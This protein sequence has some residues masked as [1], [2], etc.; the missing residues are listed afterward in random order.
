MAAPQSGLSIMPFVGFEGPA[1]TGKTF[2][3]IEA[4]RRRVANGPPARRVLGLTFMHGSRRR[5]DE[6]FAFFEETRSRSSCMT[7]DSFAWNLLWRWRSLGGVLPAANDFD[8]VC[9]ACGGLLERAEVAR[10]V[11]A[12]FPIIAID[13]AQELA[14]CRLR[15]AKALAHHS[16]MIVAA[17]EFQCLDDAIDTAP[18]QEWFGAG[19]ITRLDEVRRTD[20]RGLLDAGT[21]LRQGAAPGEGAG[22]A[23]RYEYPN[24]A[25]FAVGHVLNA[26]QG[27]TAVLVAPGSSG[28]AGEM[29]PRLA[30]GMRTPKQVV[31]PIPIRWESKPLDEAA[32]VVAEVCGGATVTSEE[33]KQR[34]SGLA[35]LAPWI[36]LAVLS[37]DYA[38]RAQ[39]RERWSREA[40]QEMLE[41]KATVHRAYGYGLSRGVPVMSIHAAK[42]RQFRNVV[43]L[44][45]PGVPG[46]QTHHARLLYNAITRAE[47]QCTVFVRTR[48]VLRAPPFAA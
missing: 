39:G 29:I 24:Q 11:T 42:N 46:D 44:W 43:V 19:D 13:E 8:Q 41:R 33:L 28:W 34:L 36:R 26:A 6:R 31:R 40:V 25:P 35:N 16:D 20:R 2:Q 22:L 18:F 15:I 23:I 47:Y 7:I 12:A 32:G 48:P 9:D 3:L 30:Q 27:S 14:P 4:V 17:D 5:L 21:A 10:W 1:G 45:S 37:V 38:R